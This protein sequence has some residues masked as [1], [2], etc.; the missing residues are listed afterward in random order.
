MTAI[1]ISKKG[2]MAI[3]KD[4]FERR[5]TMKKLC[6]LMLTVLMVIWSFSSFAENQ[7][8]VFSWR[9]IKFLMTIDEV[10]SIESLELDQVEEHS[11]SNS[12]ILHYNGTIANIEGS[13][14]HYRFTGDDKLLTEIYVTYNTDSG[15]ITVENDYKK[16]SSGLEEKYGTPLG[17]K[18]GNTHSLVGRFLKLSTELYSLSSAID[19]NYSLEYGEWL[20][21]GNNAFVKIEHELERIPS[22]SG[23]KVLSHDITYTYFTQEE[24]STLTNDL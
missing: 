9:N 24:L 11:N 8:N 5:I 13:A 18:D 2:L 20:L 10:K 4:D 16:I 14:I 22:K 15:E 1:W 17:N 19:P 21:E 7:D 12:V 23:K 6:A 3:A